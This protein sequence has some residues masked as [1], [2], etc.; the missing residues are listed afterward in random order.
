MKINIKFLDKIEWS[1]F[2]TLNTF[3]PFIALLLTR[4][5]INLK[6]M[7][8]SSIINMMEGDLLPKI[9][10]TGFLN[11]MTMENNMN[12]IIQSIVYFISVIV[13]HYIPYNNYIHQIVY[14]NNF[15]KYIFI[16][17][18][19]VWMLFILKEILSMF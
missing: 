10:F 9:L 17:A 6:T 16:I 8:F 12:W 7:V 11:F 1:M 19:I 13:V 5:N 14:K 2:A 4:Q 3:I 15:V 18:I